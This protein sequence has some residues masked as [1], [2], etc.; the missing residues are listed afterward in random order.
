MPI[1][2]IFEFDYQ[3]NQTK[4]VHVIKFWFL[5]L[6][7]ATLSKKKKDPQWIIKANANYKPLTFLS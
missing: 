1:V 5:S 4:Q 3:R 2:N 7:T 6:A